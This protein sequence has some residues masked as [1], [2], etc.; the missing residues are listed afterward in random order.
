MVIK[1]QG[2]LWHPHEEVLGTQA[3]KHNIAEY[4]T[5]GEGP[6]LLCT[7]PVLV[8]VAHALRG[9]LTNSRVSRGD[10]TERENHR[11]SQ[12]SRSVEKSNRA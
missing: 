5:R 8:D 12:E 9:M 2:C 7:G 6:A 10:P 1:T 4:R 11:P 3:S